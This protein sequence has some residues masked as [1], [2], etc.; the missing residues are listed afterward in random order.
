MHLPFR[1][2]TENSIALAVL[3]AALA[4]RA[5]G[6]ARGRPDTMRQAILEFLS[7][8]FL[9]CYAFLVYLLVRDWAP[10]A[11]IWRHWI[12]VLAITT[13]VL[14]EIAVRR[15]RSSQPDRRQPGRTLV[16]L[17]V[18]TLFLCIA[19]AFLYV[20]EGDRQSPLDATYIGQRGTYDV[21]VALRKLRP[22]DA[23]IFIDYRLG[24]EFAAKNLKIQLPDSTN[25]S[26]G[27]IIRKH[28]LPQLGDDIECA[29]E[30][31]VVV[32]RRRMK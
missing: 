26:I 21:R 19:S 23:D 5:F 24:D 8:A 22:I 16:V 3:A 32:L 25:T 17:S 31:R 7:G 9:P 28:V 4:L 10:D 12:A 6:V 18:L 2:G 14:H 1:F 27:E 30:G 11:R 20:P 13:L 15:P 29:V